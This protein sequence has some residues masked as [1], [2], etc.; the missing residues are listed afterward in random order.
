VSAENPSRADRFRA[1]IE[2]WNERGIP[3]IENRWHEDVVWEEPPGF[4]DAA[5][6][7]GREAVFDRMRQ[8][9]ELLGRVRFDVA[10]VE[11]I[12]ERLY[13]S[14]IVHGRGAASGVP[15]EMHS[16]WVYDYAEDGRLVRWRE[17]LDRDQAMAAARADG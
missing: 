9:F 12:G 5:T 6:R 4:P 2:E 13:A 15:V 16:Y 1:V 17:F 7:R 11:E 10:E 3:A 14:V 8:R